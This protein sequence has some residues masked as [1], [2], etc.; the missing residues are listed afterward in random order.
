MSHLGLKYSENGQRVYVNPEAQLPANVVTRR[1]CRLEPSSSIESLWY[2]VHGVPDVFLCEKDN[3]GL[4]FQ[5]FAV[6]VVPC[7][8]N[9]ILWWSGRYIRERSILCSWWMGLSFGNHCFCRTGHL[10]SMICMQLPPYKV[11]EHTGFAV[12]TPVLSMRCI[13]HVH[14]GLRVPRRGV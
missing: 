12:W 10:Q 5:P 11:L 4:T 1:P 14:P 2:L 9:W 8:C 7:M 3:S 6:C 13:A